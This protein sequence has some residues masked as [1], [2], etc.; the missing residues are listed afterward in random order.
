MVDLPILVLHHL[1]DWPTSPRLLPVLRA[2]GVPEA[3]LG[4]VHYFYR[5]SGKSPFAKLPEGDGFPEV[6]DVLLGAS[7]ALAIYGGALAGDGELHH[8]FH[9]TGTEAQLVEHARKVNY[10][11]VF[12]RDAASRLGDRTGAAVDAARARKM[13]DAELLEALDRGALGAADDPSKELSILSFFARL[14]DLARDERALERAIVATSSLSPSAETVAL[15]ALERFASDERLAGSTLSTLEAMSLV[16][17]PELTAKAIAAIRRRVLGQKTAS[18]VELMAVFDT[19]DDS[20]LSAKEQSRFAVLQKKAIARGD[21][22]LETWVYAHDRE[23]IDDETFERHLPDAFRRAVD[24]GFANEKGFAETVGAVAARDPDLALRGVLALVNRFN[25]NGLRMLAEQAKAL[26]K[27]GYSEAVLASARSHFSKPEQLSAAKIFAGL[28]A[29][30]GVE[31]VPVAPPAL[32]AIDVTCRVGTDV[33]ALVVGSFAAVERIA[34]AEAEH[35]ARLVRTTKSVGVETNGDG[36]YAVRIV[37]ASSAKRADDE[38]KKGAVS[39]GVAPLAVKGDMLTVSG[40]VGAGGTPTIPFPSGVYA[41]HLLRPKRHKA[42]LI[43]V[44]RKARKPPA[45]PFKKGA[46]PLLGK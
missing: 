17:S 29:A 20:P 39:L 2:I 44:V 32:D 22:E 33:A 46:L 1:S 36:Q 24:A 12:A 7:G 15:A 19:L 10:E 6:T 26:P 3:A 38:V 25:E 37:G 18:L 8:G 35:W 27:K 45:W 28:L 23:A 21:F 34:E 41:A 5:G 13:G 16:S 11:I 43:V 4:C 42:S 14:D 40:V 30:W 31:A 9:W